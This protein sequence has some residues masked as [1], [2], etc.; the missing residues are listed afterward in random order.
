MWLAGTN[1]GNVV[2]F[3]HD[4]EEHVALLGAGR[5]EH[6]LTFVLPERALVPHRGSVVASGTPAGDALLA[7]L[8]S[9]GM[10]AGLAG[11]SF[12]DTG[13]LWPPWCAALGGDTVVSVAFTARLSPLGAEA[14]VATAPEAR[15]RG[16][17]AA[18][19][20]AWSMHPTLAGRACFYT[21]DAENR[22]S[23]R[24]AER[25]GLRLLGATISVP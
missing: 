21:T 2:R 10:P 24:V 15:G 13:D 14:G 20:A 22:S 19:T 5:V 16:L 11:M 1:A 18:V 3:R 6:E 4:V 12:A 9:E 7:R 17:A 25:L 8:Q 23:R